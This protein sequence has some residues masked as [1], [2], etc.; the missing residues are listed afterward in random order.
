MEQMKWEISL[1]G[2]NV[3]VAYCSV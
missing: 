3:Q 1:F 2:K